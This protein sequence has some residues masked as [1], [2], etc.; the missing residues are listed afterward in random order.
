[1]H[2][3]N[4]QRS[5]PAQRPHWGGGW[6]VACLLLL[7]LTGCT[8][9]AGAGPIAWLRAEPEAR[10]LP[11]TVIDPRL[12]QTT[13]DA[14]EL[15]GPNLIQT[16]E[17]LYSVN[18]APCHQRNGEGNLGRFPR[19]NRSALVT[20]QDPSPLIQTVLYG[21]REMPGFVPILDDQ[22]IAAVLSYVRQAWDNEAGPVTPDQV[23]A[24]REGS[25]E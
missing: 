4:R 18:C 16:G 22:A 14:G 15:T 24:T 13:G 9:N 11:G 5:R 3:A 21:R 7:I 1:M 19:L 6:G 2:A 12:P 10:R 17:T 25:S 20:G 23:Q 8:P